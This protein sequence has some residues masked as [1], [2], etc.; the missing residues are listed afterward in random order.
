MWEKH[1]SHLQSKD[2]DKIPEGVKIFIE[3]F[4]TKLKTLISYDVHPK[5]DMI[6]S[7][8][9][10]NKKIIA[11]DDKINI[12]MAKLLDIDAPPVL[13]SGKLSSKQKDKIIEF[14]DMPMD[15]RKKKFGG[16]D[17]VEYVLSL[18]VPPSRL[19]FL[20]TTK[21][22]GVVFYFNNG[23]KVEMAKLVDPTFTQGIIDKKNSTD[24]KYFPVV[25]KL[26]FDNIKIAFD[27]SI[28]KSSNFDIL[29]LN[30][31]KYIL[32]KNKAEIKKLDKYKSTVTD[33]RFASIGFGLLPS[34][35]KKLVD[36]EWVTEDI[37]RIAF[38]LLRKE[39]KR[40][41]PSTGLTKDKKEMINTMVGK[42]KELNLR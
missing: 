19:N 32:D 33:N 40:A 21:L 30:I 20:L 27:S 23:D 13:F 15:D 17:F 31:T 36:K 7:Y 1:I 18:F 38:S 10:K 11:P 25:N 8:V 41:N 42:L 12:D 35:V 6:I 22:E 29:I 5:N 16:V 4:D 39:K 14:S 3:F 24:D 37:Y 2:I 26:V 9:T 34:S 28:D